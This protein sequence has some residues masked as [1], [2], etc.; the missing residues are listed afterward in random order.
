MCKKCI[1]MEIPKKI[2]MLIVLIA[3]T[4]HCSNILNVQLVEKGNNCER[5]ACKVFEVITLKTLG[6]FENIQILNCSGRI[7]KYKSVFLRGWEM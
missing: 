4:I 2:I 1:L 7:I 6:L 5:L 3:I